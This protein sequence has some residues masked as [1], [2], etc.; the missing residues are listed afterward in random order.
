M[1][2]CYAPTVC[3][4]RH[5]AFARSPSKLLIFRGV[6]SDSIL[7]N[8]PSFKNRIRFPLGFRRC[9]TERSLI[10]CFQLRHKAFQTVWLKMT[11]AAR[12]ANFE[13]ERGE[14]GTENA[15]ALRLA[16]GICQLSALVNQ[17]RALKCPKKFFSMLQPF[18]CVPALANSQTRMNIPPKDSFNQGFLGPPP[19]AC[20]V[21]RVNK[22]WDPPCQ[23]RR[24]RN[25]DGTRS[26]GLG[27]RSV[28][29]M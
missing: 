29:D 11:S 27:C 24:V 22:T 5:A 19:T 16:A 20:R 1:L 7:F 13:G 6:E 23:T 9:S 3:G 4:M 12:E 25:G 8:H 21:G 17:Q 10:I 18:P 28:S 14:R 15:R 26:S 2:S